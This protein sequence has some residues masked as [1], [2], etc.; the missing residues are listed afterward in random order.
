MGDWCQLGDILRRRHPKILLARLARPKDLAGTAEPQILLGD[1]KAIVG[2]AHHG[3]PRPARFGQI[4]PAQQDTSACAHAA[5][6]TPAKL[7]QLCE[8]EALRTLDDNQRRIG[9]INADLDH[10]GR[11]QRAEIA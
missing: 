11:H 1:A 3:Q 4:L 10:R 2:F 7:V 5:A 8:A 6:D 9:H